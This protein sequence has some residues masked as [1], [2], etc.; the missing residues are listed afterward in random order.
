[1]MFLQFFVWGSWFAT[2][3]LALGANGLGGSTGGVYAA[4]PLGAIFAPLFLGIIADRF[5][6]S[7]VVM[8]VLFLLGGVFLWL[9]HGAAVAGNGALMVNYSLAHL[10]CY[11][12][13]LGLGNTISFSNLSRS[14]FPKVRV[15]GTIGWIAAGLFVGIKGWSNGLEILQV[16]AV[17]SLILGV[18]SF[19]LPHTPPPAKGQPIN[20]RALFMVDAFKLL[21]KPAFFVFMLCS[22][23]ICI[24][25]AFYY[26]QTSNFLGHSG[27]VQPAASMTIGQM[28]EIVFML[29]IPFFF[30]RLGVKWMIMIGML[31]WV[32]RYVLFSYGAPDQTRWML[33]LAIA[34]HGICYD[35][36][37]VTGFMYTDSVAPKQIR[38]QA[39]SL[40]VF[41][42][43][44]I[45]MWIGYKVAFGAFGIVKKA[46]P[47]DQ[48]AALGTAVD[49]GRE[50]VEITELERLGQM[51]T[52]DMPATVDPELIT[53]GMEQWRAYWMYPAVF[54]LIVAVIFFVG[55]WDKMEVTDKDNG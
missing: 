30:R 29:M 44:G 45:G 10:L 32:L 49:D 19:F 31:A 51:F 9:A 33:F 21:A 22:L 15:W 38:G 42:T 16:G 27:F 11:M 4:A 3:A 55:F 12:P 1:M 18:Y 2:A 54:A 14:A 37:F 13:T 23:L 6:P 28:S 46:P 26:G 41:F 36:F 5:F 52:V 39:Q 8:G 25:L 47:L 48:V 17:S 20:A 40:L 43:Q 7:Q 35:F 50:K 53:S 24:P 34:L